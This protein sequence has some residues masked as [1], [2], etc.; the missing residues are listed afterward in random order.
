MF[1][2]PTHISVLILTRRNIQHVFTE[3]IYFLLEYDSTDYAELHINNF[4][5]Y[6]QKASWMNIRRHL[7]Y[8]KLIQITGQYMMALV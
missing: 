4:Q 6:S 5:L 8:D 3:F 7:G 2:M 1:T